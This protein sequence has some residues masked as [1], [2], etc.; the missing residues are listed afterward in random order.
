MI[1]NEIAFDLPY[2]ANENEIA[3][4]MKE[5][6]CLR[7]DATKIDYEQNWKMKRRNFSLQ[8]RCVCSMFER[9]MGKIITKKCSK[10]LIECIHDNSETILLEFSKVSSVKMKF[11]YD[12]FM[13]LDNI[14]KK[15][16]I[17]ELLMKGIQLFS[18]KEG[19][20]Y[21]KF[22]S[23]YNQMVEL[24]Y[25][26]QWIWKKSVKSP[27]KKNNAILIIKHDV[28][29]VIFT[30]VIK[31]NKGKEVKTDNLLTELPDEYAYAKHLGD[32]SWSD[33][34]N[35]ILTNKKGDQR[36]NISI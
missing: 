29:M 11:D 4:I 19:L 24:N 16:T 10:L 23:V 27:N 36:W 22:I 34:K 20:D 18:I 2:V 9:L 35:V 3:R 8:T 25:I 7:N 15:K 5:K 1:F 31:D 12:N 13:L 33:D 6:K 26:N 30:I 28:E 32:L 17:L 14:Q 21:E